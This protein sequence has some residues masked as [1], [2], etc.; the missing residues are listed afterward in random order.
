MKRR[1]PQ[2]SSP[3]L[4]DDLWSPQSEHGSS[5][6]LND[7]LVSN[8][9]MEFAAVAEALAPGRHKLQS[10]EYGRFLAVHYALLQNS[11]M[12]FAEFVRTRF[13][14]DHVLSKS[15][16]GQQH[17]HA[18]LKHILRPEKADALF[19]A[20]T[21]LAKKRLMAIPNWPYLDDVRFCDMTTDHVQRVISAALDKGYSVQ[22][23]KHI[24]NVIGT[25][26]THAS[27][28]R[29][30]SGDNPAFQVPLPP[31]TRR[32]RNMNA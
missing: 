29:Y 17:Y 19:D 27:R 18:I 24:R 21:T 31:M 15:P 20:E 12:T 8:S 5:E 26:I 23:V 2:K 6:E 32:R 14:P 4:V 1:K 11:R 22:T 16:A 3:D 9:E 13:I 30:F 28:R 10:T 25:V 7:E